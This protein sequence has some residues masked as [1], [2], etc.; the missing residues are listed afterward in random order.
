MIKF[1]QMNKIK[2]FPILGF[3]LVSLFVSAQSKKDI[4]ENKILSETTYTTSYE[5][6]KEVSYKDTYTVYDKNGNVIEETEYT[7]T[8][9]IKRKETNKYNANNDKTEE[10]VFDG[11]DKTTTKTVFYYNA[12]GQKI[13]EISY[14][15]SGK[16]HHQISYSYNSNGF[17]TEKKTYDAGKKLLSVKKY[18]YTNR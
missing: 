8:G 13:G 16:I 18:T 6:G 4:R 17:K 14:D 3:M 9:D 7:K 1:I 2:L 15:S 12:L 11:K 5:N 10:V